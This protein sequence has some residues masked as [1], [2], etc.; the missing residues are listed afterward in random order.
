MPFPLFVGTQNAS[1]KMSIYTS[2]LILLREDG[3]RTPTTKNA[4]V[5]A[6]PIILIA[7][8]FSS[9]A[10]SISDCN[11][12]LTNNTLVNMT[13]LETVD[14]Q[15]MTIS[16]TRVTQAQ[17]QLILQIGFRECSIGN[18]IFVLLALY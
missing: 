14:P 18:I 10:L 8:E 2:A 9:D 4:M 12:T 11:I 15:N 1:I 7:F 13:R 3:N 16:A 5:T 6:L 17:D